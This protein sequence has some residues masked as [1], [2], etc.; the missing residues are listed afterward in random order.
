MRVQLN[1]ENLKIL[2]CCHKPCDNLPA[3]PDGVFLPIF[4][5]AAIN[6]N[7]VVEAQIE[8]WRKACGGGHA[9]IY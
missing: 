6:D 4:D 1:S 2:I 9:M 5:G 3:N 8:R 7:A